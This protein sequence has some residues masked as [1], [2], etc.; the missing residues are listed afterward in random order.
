MLDKLDLDLVIRIRDSGESKDL[1]AA[2]LTY[3]F[4]V[5]KA[6]IYVNPLI[7]NHLNNIVSIFKRPLASSGDAFLLK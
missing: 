7:Y 2:E 6:H 5:S 1:T 4:S 3:E